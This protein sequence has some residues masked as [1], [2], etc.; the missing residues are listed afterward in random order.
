MDAKLAEMYGTNQVDETDVEKL[1]AAELAEKLAA[2]ESMNL[3]EMSEDDIE[4]LA[5]QVLEGDSSA[6]ETEEEEKTASEEEGE[7][8]VAD[9]D[10]EKLAEADYLGRVMAHSYVQEL[11]NIEKTAGMTGAARMASKAK[12]HG[13]KVMGH[14]KNLGGKVKDIA[15]AK[16]AREGLSAMSPV[17]NKVDQGLTYPQ[18]DQF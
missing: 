12:A 18:V 14:L 8:E 13:G 3:S 9:E 11:R 17:N 5:A 7:E 1:A 15:S 2:D 16:Q 4:A 6:E 10:Q